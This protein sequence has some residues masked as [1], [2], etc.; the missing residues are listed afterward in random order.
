MLNWIVFT[1][2]TAR[3]GYHTKFTAI[4]NIRS[5]GRIAHQRELTPVEEY[6]GNRRR[7]YF[8]SYQIKLPVNHDAGDTLLNSSSMMN[9]QSKLVKHRNDHDRHPKNR[10]YLAKTSFIPEF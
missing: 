3:R 1:P 4:Y 6:C 7:D 5:T 9:W 2:R 8:V 10:L